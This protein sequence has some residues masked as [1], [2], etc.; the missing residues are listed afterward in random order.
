MRRRALHG[1]ER[2]VIFRQ[3]H[4]PGRMGLSDFTDQSGIGVTIAGEPLPHRLYY[5]RL[6]FS[7]FEHGHVVLRGESF[8][9]LAAGLQDALWT[10]GGVPHEHRTDSLSEPRC[11]RATPRKRAS[12]FRQPFA[13]VI[14]PAGK[15]TGSRPAQ[16]RS[17]PPGKRPAPSRD[18]ADRLR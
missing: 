14:F 13:T 8:V 3:L 15:I 2:E 1:A 12:A 17:A 16:A 10:L 6:V 9:A 11:N 7:G 4:E 18:D 5:F